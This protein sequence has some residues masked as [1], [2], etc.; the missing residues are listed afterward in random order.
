MAYVLNIAKHHSIN[1]IQN[2]QEIKESIIKATPVLP[3]GYMNY[4]NFLPQTP[5]ALTIKDTEPR[6][7]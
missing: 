1:P 5:E 4:K 2:A 7:G 6:N 3:T